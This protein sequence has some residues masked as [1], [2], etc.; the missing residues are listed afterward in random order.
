M[1]IFSS[2]F[3]GSFQ[4]PGSVS[5]VRTS[6]FLPVLADM[7]S[8]CPFVSSSEVAER[9]LSEENRTVLV[10]CRSLVAFSTVHI[11]GA[12]HVNCSSLARKRLTQGKTKLKDLI[13][14][15]EGK[16]RYISGSTHRFVVYDEVTNTEE[17]QKTSDKSAIF[18]VIQTLSKEGKETS[19]LLGKKGF[20]CSLR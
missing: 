5:E 19:L 2:R 13:S 18:I 9:I 14:S 16:E 8:R 1:P 20:I 15:Q 6:Q 3:F 12:I 4:M 17:L 11:K 7:S 10:D